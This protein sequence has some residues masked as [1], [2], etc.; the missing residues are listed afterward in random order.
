MEEGEMR[1]F[2]PQRAWC[3]DSL[4]W[5]RWRTLGRTGHRVKPHARL[6]SPCL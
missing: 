5:E 6:L 4:R 3:G 2:R 1:I